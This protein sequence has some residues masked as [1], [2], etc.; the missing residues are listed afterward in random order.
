MNITLENLYV[1]EYNEYMN[2]Y[3]DEGGKYKMEENVEQLN[4]KIGRAHV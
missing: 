2:K 4:V 3:S 1:Q